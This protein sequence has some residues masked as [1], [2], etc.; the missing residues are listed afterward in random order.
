VQATDLIPTGFLHAVQSP[1]HAGKPRRRLLHSSPPPGKA[2]WAARA[3]RAVCGFEKSP[4]VDGLL[5][6]VCLDQWGGGYREAAKDLDR[7]AKYGLGHAVFVKHDWQRWGYDYRLPEIY[8]PSGGLEPFLE[9]REAARRAGMLFAPHDNYIDFYPDAEGFGYDRIVFNADGTPCKAWYNPGLDAQSYRW[10]P[11]AFM[12][13]LT[14]NMKQMREGFD[15]DALF[16]D[17]FTSIPPF[18]FY[19]RSGVFHARAKTV[20]GWRAAF[21]T[22][23]RLLGHD[24]AMLSE[25]GHDALIGSID[26]VQAD[27]W[28]PACWCT[29]FGDADRTPW[30][31]MVTHG[32]MILFAGGLGDRYDP[33][34][35]HGYG[36][37][38]LPLQHRAGRPRP[39]VRRALLA[40]RGDDLLAAA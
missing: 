39:D 13:W 26:G 30:H 9:M 36:S 34:P 16:I 29:V 11:A 31:D 25:S 37:G 1:I 3:Y 22:S 10:M 27:H 18:D 33:D 8:P 6:R 40:P 7:A 4:G 38:R 35:K 24:A 32:K 12:P 19:D 21:D 23:R 5:G 28:R 17:V 14:A 2:P 15:P 20:T